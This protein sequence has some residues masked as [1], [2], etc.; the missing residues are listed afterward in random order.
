[1]SVAARSAASAAEIQNE[2]SGERVA[3]A[4]GIPRA[5]SRSAACQLFQRG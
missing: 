2:A 1:M 4:N 5:N 3:M